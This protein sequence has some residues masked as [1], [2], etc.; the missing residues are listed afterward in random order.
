M[1]PTSSCTSDRRWSCRPPGGEEEA[2]RCFRR[3]LD[4]EPASALARAGE[5][6]VLE[7]LGFFDEA[8]TRAEEAVAIV[9]E[10]TAR[11]DLVVRL[12]RSRRRAGRLDDAAALL[13]SALAD[14][15]PDRPNDESMLRFQLGSIREKQDRH[16]EAF[17]EYVRANAAYP[18]T[19]DREAHDRL[20]ED[21][22][23]VLDAE[24]LRRLPR[25]SRVSERPLL[26][27]GMPR[28][29]TTLVEQI[30]AA[31]PLVHGGGE[32]EDLPRLAHGLSERLGT[33]TPYPRC[34][35]DLDAARIDAIAAAYLERLDAIAPADAVR[36]TDKMPIN[37]RHLGLAHLA[38]PGARV[39]HCVRD[40][41]DTCLS[42]FATPLNVTMTFATDLEA[43]G[44]VHRRYRDLMAHWSSVIDLPILEVRYED[45]VAD[46]EEQSRRLVEFAGLDWDDVCLRF[47]E[48]ERRVAT[49]SVEQVRRPMYRSSVGR[50]ARFGAHLD[51]LRRALSS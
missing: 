6:D 2:L 27:V 35:T 49:A 32:L 22:V 28:S 9:E 46:Q 3:A 42:C 26:I 37:H 44:F 5:I 50:A 18:G 33:T 10:E 4:G 43:L 40:P 19:F 12:A 16:D 41:V 48:V 14:L 11:A 7:R 15:P 1:I 20:V 8:D 24:T 30:L 36:V 21:L 13:E 34:V 17:A 29:G 38:L 47:H 31:H 51:P 45:L 39:I 25:A 23:T